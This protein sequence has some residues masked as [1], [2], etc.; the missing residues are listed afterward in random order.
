[1]RKIYVLLLLSILSVSA[2][3]A[4][5][6]HMSV[7][8]GRSPGTPSK[9]SKFF[10]QLDYSAELSAGPAFDD[11]SRFSLGVCFLAEHHFNDT[12]AV[13]LGAGFRGVQ[14]K[15]AEIFNTEYA[16]ATSKYDFEVLMPVYARLKATPY[17]FG[18]WTPAMMVDLGAAIRLTK[19]QM[20]GFFFEPAV[21]ADYK[22]NSHL[23]L[24]LALGV[25]WM[26]TAYNYENYWYNQS[27]RIGSSTTTL[28]LRMGL[29]F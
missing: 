10:K 25:N 7:Y 1:M 19:S 27:E 23:L 28:M 14:G 3:F 2:V 11:R 17:Q 15:Q 21:G 6:P 29:D 24:T 13:C 8:E 12:L 18:K 9:L 22:I 5:K 4:Q 26:Q 16:V 20:G